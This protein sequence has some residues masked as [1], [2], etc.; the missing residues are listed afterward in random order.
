MID[1]LRAWLES[2]RVWLL[3]RWE[4]GWLHGWLADADAS[5]MLVVVVLVLVAI[6]LAIGFWP[7]LKAEKTPVAEREASEG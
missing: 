5:A 2:V 3:S 1:W 6:I 4:F 7:P